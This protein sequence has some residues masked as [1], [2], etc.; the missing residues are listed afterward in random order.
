MHKGEDFTRH[1]FNLLSKQ[2]S[3]EFYFDALKD[4]GFFEPEKNLGPVPSN[5]PGFVQIPFWPA[6]TYLQ[7]V[8]KRAGET[9]NLGLAEKI[10][11]VVR[12]VTNFRDDNGEHRDNYHTY[13]RFAE[14]LG[15]LPL[16]SI[17]IDDVRLIGIWLTSRFDRGL[18]GKSLAKGLLE[19]L[20][21]SDDQRDTTHAVQVMNDCMAYEWLPEKNRRGNELVT[22]IDNYW[23]EALLNAHAK[24]FGAKAGLPGIQ[25][26]EEGLR[27]IFSDAPGSYGTRLWRPAIEPHTQNMNFRDVENRFVDGMRD[28]LAGW[29]EA[30]PYEAAEYVKNALTDPSEIIRRIAIHTVTENFDLLRASFEATIDKGLFTS[31][32]RHEVYRLLQERFAALSAEGKAKVIAALRAL[33]EPKSGDDTARRLKFTQREW[34]T[35]I[36]D[37]PEASA[38]FNELSS[39]PALGSPTDHSDFLSYHE[40]RHG[41]GPAPFGQDS[42]IAFAEDGSLVDRLNEFKEIDSWTGPTLGGLVEALETAVAASPDTFLP[43]LSDFNRAKI[44]FQHALIAG[45]KRVY[46]P[47]NAQKPPFDWKVAWPKLLAFF[48]ECLNDQAFWSAPAIQEQGISMIPGRTWMTSLIAGFLEAG[49]KHDD[50]AYAPELLSQAWELIKIL[51]ARAEP[52]PARLTDPMT[53]ALNTEKGRV[54]GALYNHALRVCRV[55]QQQ[56]KPLEEAWAPL[57]PVFDSEIAKCVDAN[58]EFSTLSASYIANLDYMSRAWLTDNVQKLFPVEYPANFESAIGGL[59]YGSPN[60]PI[61]QLLASNKI[62]DTALNM[63]LEDRHG[64][65]RIVEWICLA[66]LWGDE[67]LTS[68]LMKQIFT[69]GAEDIQHGAGFLWHVRREKMKPE[70]V[71]RVLA[72]W[73]AALAWATA[74]PTVNEILLGRLSRLAPYFSALDD[75]AKS[76]LLGVIGYVHADYSTDQMIEQLARLADSNPMGTIELLDRMFEANTPN[77]DLDYKL[78]GLLKNLYGMGFRGEVLRIIEKLRKTLPDMLSFYQELRDAKA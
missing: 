69:G 29:I 64:R 46:D 63:K 35:A 37:Q 52:E 62:L 65:E 51:L 42:L 66:Y 59:A 27:A 48:S 50:T 74:Q 19:R 73:E 23:L 38:W 75:R 33:P 13:Y 24:R 26:F 18:V 55:A 49:T 28:A 72:Y 54:I 25:I 61:Y 1:G 22:R 3:P 15:E 6:L 17:S 44:A 45:F 21:A 41:P 57:Q 76:L 67:D 56:E 40:M 47:S 16:R 4:A 39:D 12:S 9:D 30:R 2:A 14:I 78:R 7:A 77:F 53:H 36:K 5:E 58:F 32:L 70:Q 43:L 60:R 10:L 71:E 68:P 34:L 31:G 20:L 8:A 11:A